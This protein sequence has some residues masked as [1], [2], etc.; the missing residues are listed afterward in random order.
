MKYYWFQ[1][2]SNKNYKNIFEV[3]ARMLKWWETG[4]K[5]II[6]KIINVV[7]MYICM[8]KSWKNSGTKKQN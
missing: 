5:T 6:D 7:D 4:P 8:P 3:D 2:W 1:S